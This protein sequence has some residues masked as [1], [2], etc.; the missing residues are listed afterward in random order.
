MS[1]FCL[2]ILVVDRGNKKWL[3][4][5]CSLVLPPS[6]KNRALKSREERGGLG[7][8]EFSDLSRQIDD[9]TPKED[10]VLSIRPQA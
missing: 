6:S 5:D 7:G 2:T 4:R 9:Q 10:G 8:S 3:A 1:A